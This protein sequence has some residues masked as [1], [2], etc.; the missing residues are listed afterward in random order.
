MA[1]TKVRDYQRTR[2]YKWERLE[3]NWDNELL[4]LDQC[5]ALCNKYA[6]H[7]LTGFNLT[8][9]DG[10]GR[11]NACAKIDRHQ[12]CLPRW[13]RKAWIVLHEI[14]HHL[15]YDPAH[16]DHGHQYMQEYVQLLAKHYNRDLQAL[17]DSAVGYGLRVGY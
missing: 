15:A 17:R 14:A 8:A 11:R 2:V 7:T 3:F 5:Q 13:A 9:T 10:R 4:S 12:V 1:Y 16:A 6:P